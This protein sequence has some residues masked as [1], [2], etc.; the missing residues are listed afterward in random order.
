MENLNEEL[1][2]NHEED[3]CCGEECC[4][5][6]HEEKE[7]EQQLSEEEIEKIIE[8]KYSEKDEK[9]KKF[10]RECLRRFGE[11]ADFTKT[12]YVR[13]KDKVTITCLKEGHGDFK[14]TPSN[15]L[16][17]GR[18]PKCGK[19]D[20]IKKL[21]SNTS[22]FIQDSIKVHGSKY[23]YSEVDYVN[24]RTP[25]IIICPIHGRFE[26]IP[27]SHL[28][29]SGCPECAK[30]L[31]REKRSS[32]TSRFIQDSI[33]V[34]GPKY[35]Y[36]E[37][38]YV[39][40]RTPVTIICPIHGK[41]EQIP[42]SHL[43]G[44]GCP[45]C[46]KEIRREKRSSNTS[47]FIQDSIKVHGQKYIYNEVDYVNAKTPVTIICPIHGRFKQTPTSHLSGCGCPECAGHLP[48]GN[49]GFKIQ[50]ELVHGVGTY[51][52]EK[53]N[54]INNRTPVEIYDPI[55]NEYFWQ[56]PM[57]HLSGH[58]NPNRSMSSGER[59]VYS[60]LKKENIIFEREFWLENTYGRHGN[61]IR[62]DF[63]VPSYST[64]K[65][66]IEYNG[67]QHYQRNNK[68][69]NT[70]E[71]FDAQLFRDKELREYCNT[72]SIYLIEIPYTIRT[73][74]DIS[75]FLTKTIIEN[76]DPHAL[77]DYDSLYVIEEY[78]ST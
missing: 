32:N 33:K 44:C 3:C 10:I 54:Y 5:H 70:L 23:I 38:D 39:D 41:F 74:Q 7:I 55:F 36:S 19:E 71:D 69:H 51:G 25:V 47:R 9:T 46:G 68:F 40:T 24:E 48:L 26:Q 4:C 72:N 66:I 67:I 37:V 22:K 27:Y 62:V 15:F 20:G 18:C 11:I 13:S 8:E 56:S 35:I 64:H 78:N 65:I 49:E 30:E 42:S 61:R 16:T 2:H 60:W 12:V 58:G 1:H 45:E 73:F 63:L 14:I 57:S 28:S 43:S 76:I 53:V 34:H 6:D 17:R 77:I 50:G 59:Q 52:Y 31:R 29:G 21:S 75:D